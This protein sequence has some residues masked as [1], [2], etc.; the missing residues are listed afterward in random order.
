MNRRD[1]FGYSVGIAVGAIAAIVAKPIP[2]LG[3][4]RTLPIDCAIPPNTYAINHVVTLV[5]GAVARDCRFVMG[6]KGSFLVKGRAEF[7]R[8][9]FRTVDG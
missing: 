2:L 9:Y 6:P 4:P 1:F 3:L 5:D 8:C 7:S